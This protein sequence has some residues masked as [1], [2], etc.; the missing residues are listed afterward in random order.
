MRIRRYYGNDCNSVMGFNNGYQ[1][2]M[3]NINGLNCHETGCPNEGS[4]DCAR[5]S[6]TVQYRQIYTANDWDGLKYCKSCAE[7]VAQYEYE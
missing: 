7:S 6:E 3:L 1:C 2:E 4:M 5:C